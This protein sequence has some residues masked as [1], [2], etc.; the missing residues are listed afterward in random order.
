MLISFFLAG[1][2]SIKRTFF[3]PSFGQ[4][5]PDNPFR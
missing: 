4:K 1:F 3:L 2:K 5:C